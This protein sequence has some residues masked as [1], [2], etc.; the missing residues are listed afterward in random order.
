MV[1]PMVLDVPARAV[2]IVLVVQDDFKFL[3][4]QIVMK[5]GLNG[6]VG[7]QVMMVDMPFDRIVAGVNKMDGR[8][9]MLEQLRSFFFGSNPR[10][11]WLS[12]QSEERFTSADPHFRDWLC[13]LV[14]RTFFN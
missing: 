11:G 13:L 6:D 12:V 9:I 10:R 7:P 2:A 14:H 1:V 4:L 5:M 3:S 8:H